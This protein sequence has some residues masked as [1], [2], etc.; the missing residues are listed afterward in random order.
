MIR[1]S[2]NTKVPRNA[3]NNILY[4]EWS[5]K[6]NITISAKTSNPL[7]EHSIEISEKLPQDKFIS[8]A[9]CIPTKKNYIKL[10]VNFHLIN[11]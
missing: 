9:G 4:P 10:K 7:T 2:F 5:K 8:K 3:I 6:H 1:S 11:Y